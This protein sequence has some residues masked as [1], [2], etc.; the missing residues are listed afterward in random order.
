LSVNTSWI[1]FSDL[2]PPIWKLRLGEEKFASTN[3]TFLLKS[4]ANIA[5]KL[6][7]VVVLPT[8]PFIAITPI[9]FAVTM[10]TPLH[11]IFIELI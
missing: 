9:V 1:V 11:Y 6:E 10:L 2:S 4:R 5:A 7:A 3:S 8:P